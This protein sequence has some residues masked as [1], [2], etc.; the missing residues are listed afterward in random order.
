MGGSSNLLNEA[1]Q[2]SLNRRHRK[3]RFF[4]RFC[5]MVT[6]LGNILLLVL[7]YQIFSDGLKWLD[8]DFLSSFPSRFA[9]RGGIFSALA[10]TL[11]LISLVAF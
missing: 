1:Q 6:W 9:E 8:V 7:L 3:A 2:A 11:W 5:E 4:A 10:G